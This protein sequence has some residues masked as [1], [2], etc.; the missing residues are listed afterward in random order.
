[1]C[2]IASRSF[3]EARELLSRVLSADSY[4]PEVCIGAFDG[5]AL[6]LANQETAKSGGMGKKDEITCITCGFPKETG[7]TRGGHH[8]APRLRPDQCM[9]CRQL[10]I[11]QL[12]APNE[13][14]RLQQQP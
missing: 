6:L 4:F 2:A 13:D 12:I 3:R 14:T 1:M 8:H 5:L 10:N 9:L 11:E 7:V